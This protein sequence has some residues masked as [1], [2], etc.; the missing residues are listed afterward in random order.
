MCQKTPTSSPL[1]NLHKPGVKGLYNLRIDRKPRVCYNKDTIKR[2][3]V[4][5]TMTERQPCKRALIAIIIC[6]VVSVLVCV[7]T[8]LLATATHTRVEDFE[9][10]IA[11]AD[12]TYV[13]RAQVVGVDNEE[14]VVACVDTTGNVWEFYGV[15]DWCEGDFVL[16]L[17]DTCGTQTIY[18]DTVLRTTADAFAK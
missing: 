17:M 15:E 4:V 6:T 12:D 7:G 16:L 2:E 3:K 5:I 14:D 9:Q 1:C 18:D 13:L 10:T 8:N 11:Q